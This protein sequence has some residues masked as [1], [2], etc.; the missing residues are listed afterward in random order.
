M[1]GKD[2]NKAKLL[3]KT[4]FSAKTVDDLAKKANKYI[5]DIYEL[6]T[7]D[8]YEGCSQECM[9][10]RIYAVRFDKLTNK[11]RF[12]TVL[13]LAEI[14]EAVVNQS[15]LSLDFK[16]GKIEKTNVINSKDYMELEKYVIDTYYSIC[17]K[18][19]L[20]SANFGSKKV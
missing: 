3:N 2:K 16:I 7:D 18:Y 12:D 4:V 14:K 17:G 20:K 8:K 15:K 9:N 11:F 10:S 6:N 1:Y 5:K 13:K 19:I